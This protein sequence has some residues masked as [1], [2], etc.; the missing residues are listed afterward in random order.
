VTYGIIL[1]SAL[2]LGCTDGANNDGQN[3]GTIDTGAPAIE[4]P[5]VWINEFVASN[6]AGLQDELG[7]F[8]DWIELYNASDADA[9]LG[10]WWLT[11]DLSNPFKFQIAEGVTVPAQGFLVFFADSDPEEGNLHAS[12]N[13]DAAGGEDIGL[14]GPNVL[15][16]P[17]V[18]SIEA[19]E[20]L[21]ADVSLARMPDGGSAW[22]RDATPT[23]GE[24]NN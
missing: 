16:N 8:P 13:L 7:A 22:D 17:L 4:L 14:Y 20:L 9:D 18:D 24:S 10:G 11:D 12:F 19:F 21:I 15:D 23:P 5:D 2:L 1:Q 6:S 3:D